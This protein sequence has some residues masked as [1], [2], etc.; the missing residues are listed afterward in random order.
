MPRAHVLAATNRQPSRHFD[1][2][3]ARDWSHCRSIR[4]LTQHKVAAHTSIII[5]IW[6]FNWNRCT[7]DTFGY[8]DGGRCPWPLHRLP[9]IRWTTNVFDDCGCR[10]KC[11][12]GIRHWFD[13]SMIPC[14]TCDLE[15]VERFQSLKD[16]QTIIRRLW[17]ESAAASIGQLPLVTCTY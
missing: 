16:L 15:P 8:P 9:S 12:P 11:D 10:T 6:A 5:T 1:A 14:K 7:R 13:T 3:G 17:I 4:C 2:A